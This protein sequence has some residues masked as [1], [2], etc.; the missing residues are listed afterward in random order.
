[1][2]A[3]LKEKLSTEEFL[4]IFCNFDLVYDKSVDLLKSYCQ[5]RESPGEHGDDFKDKVWTYITQTIPT[6]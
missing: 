2:I 6:S 5:T 4:D 1:V 3:E